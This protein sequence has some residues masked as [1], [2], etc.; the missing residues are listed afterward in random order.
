MAGRE[1]QQ[2]QHSAGRSPG[3]SLLYGTH[4]TA[5]SGAVEGAEQG[6]QQEVPHTCS[7][8]VILCPSLIWGP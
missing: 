8:K 5:C 1:A 6:G 2:G 4:F 7:S 3:A